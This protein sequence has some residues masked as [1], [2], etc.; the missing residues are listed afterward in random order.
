MEVL[1]PGHYYALE[2]LD[3]NCP[4]CGSKEL[5][6][7]GDG[8]SL[9]CLACNHA[10]AQ[11]WPED[12]ASPRLMFVKREGA[13]YPGNVGSHPGVTVQEVLRVLIDRMKYV[14]AQIDQMDY[15]GSAA[16]HG[17]NEVVLK[18]LRLALME[19]ELRAARRRG[20][21]L[22]WAPDSIDAPELVPTCDQCGHVC[23]MEDHS[24]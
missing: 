10:W 1:D 2:S 22:T 18:S 23:C 4:N 20:H 6:N 17:H 7:L 3:A 5:D 14:D 11:S 21:S 13:K 16:H 8:E 15:P 9:L 12:G 24:L 19:L